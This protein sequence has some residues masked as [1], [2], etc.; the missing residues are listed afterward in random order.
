M[1]KPNTPE[2]GDRLLHLLKDTAGQIQAL[3]KATE[4]D[5]KAIEA[6]NTTSKERSVLLNRVKA[7]MAKSRELS[8]AFSRLKGMTGDY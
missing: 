1:L 5:C 4:A 7:R 3:K 6:P 8:E 2:E